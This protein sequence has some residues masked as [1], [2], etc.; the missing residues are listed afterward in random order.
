MIIAAALLW[1]TGASPNYFDAE[2]RTMD[3]PVDGAVDRPV[4]E[5]PG[6][7]GFTTI[8]TSP[9]ISN[10][11]ARRAGPVLTDPNLELQLVYRGVAYPTQM[12]FLSED[13]ILVLQKNDGKI[14]RITDCTLQPEPILDVEVANVIE[15]G[16]LGI[17]LSERQSDGKR[18][19]FVYFTPAFERDGDDAEGKTPRG[20]KLYRYEVVNGTFTEATSIFNVPETRG[21][22]R[23]G[24]VVTIGPDNNLYFVVGD[25]ASTR[26]R[27]QNFLNSSTADTTS[28]I[29]RL[30]FDGQSPGPILA[31]GDPLNTFYAYGVRNSF[32][33]DFD[34]VTGK[35][36]DTENGPSHGDEINIVE[37]GFNSGWRMI[38]GFPNST[39]FDPDSELV[40]CL[41]C[42]TLTGFFDRLFYGYILGIKEGVYSD[43]EFV[44]QNPV[45]VTSIAFLDSDKLGPEYTNDI[46]V[47]DYVPGNLYHFELN[48]DRTA[49]VLEGPLADKVANNP[50]E[51]ESAVFG[52]GFR[53]ITDL[54]VGED[55]FLYI[56]EYEQNGSIY[57]IVPRGTPEP[58]AQ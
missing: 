8:Q 5:N 3:S 35:L 39:R 43:P 31:N 47:G 46:F 55:G 14:Q 12:D 24:G 18:Y 27:S 44:W 22:W 23:H 38:M 37:P 7:D 2:P 13:D 21:P 45:A 32:G 11:S 42:S 16:L 53:A 52:R 50:D 17:T 36:W 29:I 41:Y 51:L 30:N 25:I 40:D 57:R 28:A 20:G 58:C 9:G 6:L 54:E 48:E 10:S 49:L 4:M 56:L 26:T 33:L 1:Q 15:R 19:A 34:P